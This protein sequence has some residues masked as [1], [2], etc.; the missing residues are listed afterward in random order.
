MNILKKLFLVSLFCSLFAVS[1]SATEI[2]WKYTDDVVNFVNNNETLLDNLHSYISDRWFYPGN[3]SSYK[4]DSNLIIWDFHN[5]NNGFV[6]GIIAS[7]KHPSN[8][9]YFQYSSNHTN[10]DMFTENPYNKISV[11]FSLSYYKFDLNDNYEVVNHSYADTL[12]S[13]SGATI[14]NIFRY[15]ESN[16]L[17]NNNYTC[18]FDMYF[19]TH[20]LG[21]SDAYGYI[22]VSDWFEDD[23]FNLKVHDTIYNSLDMISFKSFFDNMNFQILNSK[24]QLNSLG[25]YENSNVLTYKINDSESGKDKELKLKLTFLNELDITENDI[26]VFKYGSQVFTQKSFSCSNVGSD[27]VCEFNLKYDVYDSISDKIMF[28][29]KFNNSYNVKVED[30]STGNNIWSNYKDVEFEYKQ[31]NFKEISGAVFY[32]RN[33]DNYGY[34][35]SYFDKD[36][37]KFI[38]SSGIDFFGRDVIYPNDLRYSNTYLYL[39]NNNNYNINSSNFININNFTKIDIPFEFD[40]SLLSQN[41]FSSFV[42]DNRNYLGSNDVDNQDIYIYYNSSLFN[43]NKLK[44]SV[45]VDNGNTSTS[46]SPENDYDFII[47]GS[48]QTRPSG[49]ANGG[50]IFEFDDEIKVQYRTGLEYFRDKIIDMFNLVSNFFNTMPDK[51]RICFGLVFVLLIGISIFRLLL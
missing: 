9:I 26:D 46:V 48:Q 39:D 11:S 3:G 44:Y 35:S 14:S 5:I 36:Y 42:F 1:V 49:S 25:T 19:D 23:G 50:Y 29:F 17:Y 13:S 47:N 22:T 27:S 21:T 16:A 8:N 33:Y 37:F 45:I 4:Y 2:E 40:S 12:Y 18:Y 28:D 20:F 41:K 43:I 6:Y 15:Y 51:F 32:L 24:V 7:N 38:I 10:Y 34:L 30:S 31:I